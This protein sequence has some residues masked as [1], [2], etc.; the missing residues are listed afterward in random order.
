MAVLPKG[1]SWDGGQGCTFGA[2]EKQLSRVEEDSPLLLWLLGTS[3]VGGLSCGTCLC[4]GE[5][6][7]FPSP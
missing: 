7:A 6:R 2:L 4:P 3:G 5:G 1:Y